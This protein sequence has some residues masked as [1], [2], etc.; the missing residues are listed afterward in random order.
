MRWERYVA[1][2]GEK[3]PHSFD[4]KPEG[5]KSLGRPS[6]RWEINI[7][8]EPKVIGLENVDRIHLA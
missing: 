8:M 5:K 7:K 1:R 3:C 2:I 4:N 6:R